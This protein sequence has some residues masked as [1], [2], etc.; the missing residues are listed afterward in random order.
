MM[1]HFSSSKGLALLEQAIIIPVALLVV[2][3]ALDVTR[4]I[5]AYSAVHEAVD[6]TLRCAAA[7]DS[8]ECTSPPSGS[9]YSDFN[10]VW[11]NPIRTAPYDYSAV[12]SWLTLGRFEVSGFSTKVLD[13]ASVSYS[14]NYFRAYTPKYKAV[15]NLV[16]IEQKKAFPRITGTAPGNMHYQRNGNDVEFQKAKI[17]EAGK[18]ELDY[19]GRRSQTFSITIDEAHL[20]DLK[21]I[22]QAAKR[23]GCFVSPRFSEGKL[24]ASDCSTPSEIVID[25]N[26]RAMLPILVFVQGK[27]DA[28]SKSPGKHVSGKVTMEL[29]HDGN[30]IDLGGRVFSRNAWAAGFVPRGSMTVNGE[31]P[32]VDSSTISSS[33]DSDDDD[34]DGQYREWEKYSKLQI[35]VKT[36][37]LKITFELKLTSKTRSKDVKELWW[38]SDDFAVFY[39]VLK[40]KTFPN[41]QTSSDFFKHTC[42]SLKPSEK[43]KLAYKNSG[44]KGKETKVDFIV[45]DL[46]CSKIESSFTN[47]TSAC[48]TSPI[49]SYLQ[50]ISAVKNGTLEAEDFEVLES[51]PN[52]TLHCENFVVTKA[53]SSANKGTS[54][55]MNNGCIDSREAF[56]LCGNN[57]LLS[58]VESLTAAGIEV[59]TRTCEKDKWVTLQKPWWKSEPKDCSFEAEDEWFRNNL[60]E[61]LFL[62]YQINKTGNF[63]VSS[64]VDSTAVR[65][66][67]RNVDP[68]THANC[69]WVGVGKGNAIQKLNHP[70]YGCDWKDEAKILFA[71]D[72]PDDY[73]S[74]ESPVEAQKPENVS[75]VDWYKFYEKSAVDR[76]VIAEP[77]FKIEKGTALSWLRKYKGIHSATSS[78]NDC[79]PLFKED[80]FANDWCTYEPFGQVITETGKD[81][82]ELIMENLVNYGHVAINAYAPSMSARCSENASNTCSSFTVSEIQSPETGFKTVTAKAQIKNINYILLP[83]SDVTYGGV[84]TKESEFIK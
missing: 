51:E 52:S 65:H 14:P 17:S 27:G 84:R 37:N 11:L 75:L 38:H 31:S 41:V 46:L 13:S 80:P 77:T 19:N 26:N 83:K 61:E 1:S 4:Y 58:T 59:S 8:R 56:D 21:L 34:S 30:S 32:V 25:K 22:N 20:R 71:G 35:P 55:N 40:V 42:A 68:K 15:G 81:G 53:C 10:K 9:V 78:L 82:P 5:Q 57:E 45:S 69:P 48:T 54:V 67:G 44:N 12:P 43:T 50:E 62:G 66:T 63:S 2:F 49:G 18:I 70:H 24:I 47:E 64:F 28:E 36:R 23:N 79:A 39:P 6:K 76:C 7:T 72:Y 74:F 16:V 73:L 60:P 29:V 33:L 3:A